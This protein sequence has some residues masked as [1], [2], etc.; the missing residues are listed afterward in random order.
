MGIRRV[1]HFSVS[2]VCC[3]RILPRGWWTSIVGWL[4]SEIKFCCCGRWPT[5]SLCPVGRLDDQAL[6][7]TMEWAFELRAAGLRV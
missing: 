2:G 7:A 5:L 4:I 6:N 3:C 1:G